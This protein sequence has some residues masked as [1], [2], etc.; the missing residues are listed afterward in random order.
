MRFILSLS[1]LFLFLI[2]HAQ[3]RTKIPLDYTMD[4][5]G[6]SIDDFSIHYSSIATLDIPA[7]HISISGSI[8]PLNQ[9]KLLWADK[10]KLLMLQK[11][12][13]NHF[14]Q[15]KNSFWTK[16]ECLLVSIS[17]NKEVWQKEWTVLSE[18]PFYLVAQIVKEG[19]HLIAC[20]KLSLNKD[21]GKVEL[22]DKC[23][24]RQTM[25][26]KEE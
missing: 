5:D 1:F 11:I 16:E 10:G 25:M 23:I 12:D 18:E 15:P 8:E 19:Q 2:T 9:N 3:K 22:I 24:S 6:D 26:L 17:A 7:S 13:S 14:I 20:L 21:N 4:I